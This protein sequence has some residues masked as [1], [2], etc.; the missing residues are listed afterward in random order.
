[1]NYPLTFEDFSK[2]L[3]ADVLLALVCRACGEIV[4]PPRMVCP[5][6]ATSDFDVVPLEG[7]GCIKSFTTTYV[8]PLGREAEAPYTIVLVEL[9]EGPWIVGN[10]VDIDPYSVSMDLIGK[11][12]MLRHKVFPGDLY[13]AGEAARPL[14]CFAK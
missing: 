11:S 8:A 1:M 12:V 10:L 4:C 3:K 13:S 5:Q 6:C 2:S 7:R 14:F 9:N